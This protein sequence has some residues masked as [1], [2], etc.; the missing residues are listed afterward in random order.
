LPPIFG[1][2]SHFCNCESEID[3]EYSNIAIKIAKIANNLL[4]TGG[5]SVWCSL[6]NYIHGLPLQIIKAI[7][8]YISTNICNIVTI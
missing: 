7:F 8:T 3:K 1:I 6:I 4:G 5:N 2:Q